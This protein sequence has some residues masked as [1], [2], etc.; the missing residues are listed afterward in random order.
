NHEWS[1]PGAAGYKAYWGVKDK[2]YYSFEVGTWHLIALDSNCRSVGGCD[3]ASPQAR[4]LLSDLAAHPADCILAFMHH[5]RWSSGYH[6]SD[7]GYD[8]FWRLLS[9]A[10]A[11]VMLAGHD[12]HY[13]RFGPDRGMRQFI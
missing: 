9:D 6:G 10:G 5:P 13:E 8:E 7:A 12:H 2:T 4:W 11:D 3:P 1:T